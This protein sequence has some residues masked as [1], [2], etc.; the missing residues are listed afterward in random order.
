MIIVVKELV[1]ENL[2]TM[3][4]NKAF[5]VPFLT[6]C[7]QPFDSKGFGASGTKIF[8]TTI[9]HSL[10]FIK[11]TRDGFFTFTTIEAFHMP[12]L[13]QRLNGSSVDVSM[14]SGTG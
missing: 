5:I 3:K 13:S 11:E 8:A 1:G 10:S 14:T 2:F 7:S 4:T 6:Q 12:M 9:W